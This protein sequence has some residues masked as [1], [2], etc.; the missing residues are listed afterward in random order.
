MFLLVDCNNF[1]ASC[2]MV[3]QPK[4]K[5]KAVVVLSNNDGCVIARS[6]EAKEM[7]IGMGEPIFHYK[8]LVEKKEL[9]TFSSNF[10]LYGDM[11]QRVQQILFTFDLPIEIYSIDEAFLS[12]EGFS[13]SQLEKLAFVIRQRIKKWCGI[14]VSIGISKTKT[15]AKV[16]NKMA[17]KLS[18]GICLLGNEIE[19]KKALENTK[20]DDVWGIGY[21]YGKK[22]KKLGIFTAKKLIE[23]KDE[24]IKTKLTVTGLRTTFEL[25][26]KSCIN[27]EDIPPPQRSILCSRSFP[28]KLTSFNELKEAISYFVSS[29]ANKLRKQKM[30]AGYLSVFIATSPF[31]KKRPFYGNSSHIN[32]SPPCSFTGDLIKNAHIALKEIYRAHLEYK[33]AGI[34]LSN[35]S[36]ENTLQQDLFSPSISCKKKKSLS[37]AV[38]KINRKQKKQS[39]FFAAEGI[40]PKWKNTPAKKSYKYTT[41]WDELLKIN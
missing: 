41:S 33:K 27:W 34:L 36:D 40:N 1:Y 30:T 11:S 20:I 31:D 21:R 38:D 6:K 5:G 2:E 29:G 12:V 25:R 37:S 16:A 39:V 19:I 13:N 24:F 10:A 14:V 28:H 32:L 35:F 18:T 9:I 7:N 23:Q 3:F 17:K 8:S 26:G 15:L 22:L 4:L